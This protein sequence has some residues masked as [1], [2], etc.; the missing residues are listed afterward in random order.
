MAQE[1]RHFSVFATI[2]MVL[3]FLR[4]I[5]GVNSHNKD[6]PLSTNSSSS[7]SPSVASTLR[8]WI[9]LNMKESNLSRGNLDELLV[10]AEEG[11]EKMIKVKKDGSADFKTV[12]D[13]VNSIP[14]GNAR[15]VVIWIGGGEFWEKITIDRT[16]KFVTF[17]GDPN[18]MPRIVYNGTAADYGTVNSATVAVESDYFVAVNVA[19]VNSAPIPNGRRCGAQAV[20]MRISGDKA[21]FYNCRFVG[22][23]DTLCD[24]KGRHFFQDCYIQGTVDFIFGNG[25]SLYLNTTIYSVAKKFG[26]ITAQAREKVNDDS[27]FTFVFC[28]ITGIGNNTTYLGRAWKERPR[29]VFARTYM[30]TIINGEGWSNDRHPDRDRTVYYGEYKCSGPGSVSSARVKFARILNDEEAKL[31]MSMTYIHGSNWLLPPPKF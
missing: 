28:N 10:A 3:L 31:F 14:S 19:F 1:L 12:T 6:S 11:G 15:R 4:L 5:P 24:D 16:K 17:Y 25:K 22:Y 7:S 13:A 27:G 18:N 29:V 8:S 23:Q 9:A 21:A 20:A 26:A 30:G 2:S